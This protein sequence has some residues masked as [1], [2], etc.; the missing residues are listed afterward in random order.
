MSQGEAMV[1]RYGYDGL[2][3][4]VKKHINTQSPSAAKVVN[5]VWVCSLPSTAADLMR[6]PGRREFLEAP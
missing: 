2:R 3:R 1:A 4:R 6:R 5:I